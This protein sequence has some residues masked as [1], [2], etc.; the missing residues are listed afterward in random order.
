MKK[1]VFDIAKTFVFV[2]CVY[3]TG[4]SALAQTL[5]SSSIC[6]KPPTYIQI[7]HQFDWFPVEQKRLMSD[8]QLKCGLPK[9][10]DWLVRLTEKALKARGIRVT[11]RKLSMATEFEQAK[12]ELETDKDDGQPRSILFPVKYF[13]LDNTLLSHAEIPGNVREDET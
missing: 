11:K 5:S 10:V 4:S 8:F 1:A 12:I 7:Y 3:I 13:E 9:D 2:I 6:P